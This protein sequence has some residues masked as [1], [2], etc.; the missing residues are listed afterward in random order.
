[1]IIIYSR[2]NI[3]TFLSLHL[4]DQQCYVCILLSLVFSNVCRIHIVLVSFRY[5]LSNCLMVLNVSVLLYVYKMVYHIL[6]FQALGEETHFD[7]MK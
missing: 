6:T 1:M 4:C 2:Y 7:F 3:F 5:E